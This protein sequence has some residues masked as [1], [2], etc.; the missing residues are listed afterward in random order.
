MGDLGY[1][2]GPPQET[3]APGGG[4]NGAGERGGP[5][6]GVCESERGG[7]R[8][9]G[10]ER[11]REAGGGEPGRKRRGEERRNGEELGAERHTETEELRPSGGGERE[12]GTRGGD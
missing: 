9:K 11:G 2:L 7:R 4:E 6:G 10:G 12:G 3:P 8:E 1:R 5:S